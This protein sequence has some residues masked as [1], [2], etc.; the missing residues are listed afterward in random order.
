MIVTCVSV[1]VKQEYID[2][3]IKACIENHKASVQE[4][5]NL[6][7]DV[8]QGKEDPT[9]FMLYEAYE[10][11]E[12]SANHKKTEHYNKWRETVTD[13]MAKPRTGTPYN[14]IQPLDREMW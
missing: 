4:S 11:E 12:A 10:T 3:F 2:A 13:Y 9:H 8:L 5:G 14:V 7:F 6:R 1:Y